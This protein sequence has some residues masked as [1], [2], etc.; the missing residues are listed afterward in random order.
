MGGYSAFLVA[1]F[2]ETYGH[3]VD[4]VPA[5]PVARVPFPLL[6]DTHAG[7]QLWNDLIGWDGDPHVSPLQARRLT[8][9][10]PWSAM[11]STTPMT[12]PTPSRMQA[13]NSDEY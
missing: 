7:G 5:G 9:C 8:W 11:P 13:G 4:G 3:A 2:T 12:A 1:L 6:D 10:S